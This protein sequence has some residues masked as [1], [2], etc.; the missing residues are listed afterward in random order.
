MK[1][2]LSRLALALSAFVTLAPAA[3]AQTV[4]NACYVPSI[5]AVYMINRTGLPANCLTGAHVAITWTDGG[6]TDGSVTTVKL[7]DGSVTTIKLADLAIATAKLADVSVT[8][9]KLAD[10]SV[11]TGK[12]AA[13]SVTAAKLGA[14]VA[15]TILSDGSITT[16]KLSDGSVTTIKLADA[17]VTTAKLSFDPATQAELDAYK[18]SLSTAGTVNTPTNPIDFSQLK[19]VPAASAGDIT[20]VVAGNG[21]TGGGTTGDV[22]LSANF[23]G[24]GAATTVAR[25]DHNHTIGQQNTRVGLDALPVNTS[26]DFN[27]AFGQGALFSN[28]TGVHNTALGYRTLFFNVGGSSN[29]AV[30]IAALD[31]NVSGNSNTAVGAAAMVSNVSAGQNVGIGSFALNSMTTGLW[32]IGI[33]DGAL[34]NFTGGNSNVAV[35]Q[36]GLGVLA[37][38]DSNIAVG[39]EAGAGLSNGSRNIYIGNSGFPTESDKIR[40]GNPLNVNART[41]IAGIRGVTTAN[42]DAIP[43][44]ISGEGQLGTVSS[45][46]RFKE[47]IRDM[48]DASRGLLG[49]RPV[50]FRYRQPTK[51]GSKPVH[52]GLIAEEVALTM[53]RLVDFDSTGTP[54]TVYYH[55]LPAMLL[56]EIQRQER[57]LVSLRKSVA[58]LEAAVAALQAERQVRR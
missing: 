20:S 33:G 32:N 13:G 51:D 43:V 12:L 16:V 19:N 26:G 40:I 50:Q 18:T 47:D 27:S 58:A 57:E 31:N 17:A 25:S 39:R 24:S 4:F 35:G 29:V 36:A 5:G 14:D 10:A 7:A 21:L 22:T 42:N 52:Y 55:I 41:Y 46:A 53:P 34:F 48:G 49:L 28:T 11:T 56:N 3:A 45:S 15:A 6:V 54:T 2:L 9:G 44:L 8:T 1:S 37:S 23:A 38:G 30:G